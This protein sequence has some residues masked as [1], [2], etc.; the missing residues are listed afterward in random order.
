MIKPCDKCEFE[1]TAYFKMPCAACDGSMFDPKV[2]KELQKV[3][4]ECQD[5]LRRALDAIEEHKIVT[6]YVSGFKVPKPVD[7]KLWNITEELR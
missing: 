6:M 1:D 3:L 7:V 4:D 2:D 5:R